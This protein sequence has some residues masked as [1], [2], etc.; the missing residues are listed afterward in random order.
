MFSME[1]QVRKH[2][3]SSS[4]VSPRTASAMDVDGDTTRTQARGQREGVGGRKEGGEKR[5]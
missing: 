3:S 1:R 5:K 4:S 2:R